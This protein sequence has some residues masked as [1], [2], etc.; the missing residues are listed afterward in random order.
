MCA[1]GLAAGAGAFSVY[2]TEFRAVHTPAYSADDKQYFY[3]LAALGLGDDAGRVLRRVPVGPRLRW[4]SV[5]ASAHS[6]KAGG[7]R[8]EHARHT[9]CASRG[10][11]G[12]WSV[13]HYPNAEDRHLPALLGG[14]VRLRVEGNFRPTPRHKVAVN[15]T[16][17]CGNEVNNRYELPPDPD[18]IAAEVASLCGRGG[19]I[20]V[21]L[22]I[23]DTLLSAR[24]STSISAAR[25]ES[26]GLWS[27]HT[28]FAF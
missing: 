16:S 28:P 3:R 14:F 22:T 15:L 4:V 19:V 9:L 18:A 8:E 13:E 21:H 26:T 6:N 20:E 10:T 2:V 7:D 12:D 5:A 1:L 11:G 17:V 23:E 25:M 24:D 27:F